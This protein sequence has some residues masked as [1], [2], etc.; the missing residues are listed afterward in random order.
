V[1]ERTSDR[2]GAREEA[3]F[4]ITRVIDAPCE[5]V[6]AAGTEARHMAQ[7]WGP[8]TYSTPGCE[9]DAYSGG[10]CRIVMR[11]PEGVDYPVKGVFHEVVAPS[12]LVLTMDCSEHPPAW[13]DLVKPGR[14]KRETNPAGEMLTTVTFV[15]QQGKTKL[16]ARMRP[17]SAEICN[18]ML[19]MGMTQG[20]S[21]SL[22]LVATTAVPS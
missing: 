10:A 16:T 9:L 20:W 15:E 4:V 8:D 22:D 2:A 19:K 14:A 17:A 6:F 11:S 12:Q 1:S 18:A 13:H 3:E 7:W 21:Q 5:F